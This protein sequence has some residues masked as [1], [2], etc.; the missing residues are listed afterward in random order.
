MPSSA[1]KQQTFVMLTQV[2]LPLVI[3]SNDTSTTE[4]YTLSLHDAL[5]IY[6]T[7]GL[8][9]AIAIL[10]ALAG[11]SRTGKGCQVDFSMLDGQVALLTLAGEHREVHLA[12]IGRAH[13]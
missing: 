8:W 3:F 10:A 11:R 4:I 5:P 7:S 6:L 12:E 13:V 1:L 2:T 9:V